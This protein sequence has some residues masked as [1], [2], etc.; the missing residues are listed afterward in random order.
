MFFSILPNR[1][2]EFHSQL[3]R[4]ETGGA[5]RNFGPPRLGG[6]YL[7][8]TYS[9]ASDIKDR[10]SSVIASSQSGSLYRTS[11]LSYPMQTDLP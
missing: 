10:R 6:V 8:L 5:G 3:G 2:P 4:N 9:H 7:R 11:H 1:D